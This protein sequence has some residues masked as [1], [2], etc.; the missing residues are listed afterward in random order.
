MMDEHLDSRGGDG[1]EMARRVLKTLLR[2]AGR[3]GRDAAVRAIAHNPE[4]FFLLPDAVGGAKNGRTRV[5]TPLDYVSI[6]MG[7]LSRS[8]RDILLVDGSVQLACG[9]DG[10]LL[11]GH[12][13][14]CGGGRGR[15]IELPEAVIRGDLVV[16]GLEEL[17]SIYARVS[18]EMRLAQVPGL[19]ELRGEVFG[20]CSLRGTG[21]HR[22]GADFRCARDLSIFHHPYLRSINCEVGG[23]LTVVGSA[24]ERT[25]PAFRSTDG[26]HFSDC[27]YI[28]ELKGATGGKISMRGCAEGK[29]GR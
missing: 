1:Y 8:P 12:E 24:L 27:P 28:Q 14:A 16:S 13:T 29:T 10:L 11:N 7:A 4:W 17:R 5:V 3:E 26:A 2:G 25:G 19:K 21:L 20:V 15:L 6:S 9:E 22:I 18:G 23:E